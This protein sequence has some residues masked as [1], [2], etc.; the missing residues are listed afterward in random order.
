MYHGSKIVGKKFPYRHHDKLLVHLL[1]I[2]KF[3]D[4]ERNLKGENYR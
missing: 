3:I 4:Y 2:F 1:R